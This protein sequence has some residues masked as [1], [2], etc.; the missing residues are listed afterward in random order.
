MDATNAKEIVVSAHEAS[1][2][3][4]SVRL[5]L[6][7]EYVT[8]DDATIGPHV[9]H[10]ENLPRP[11]VFYRGGGSCC[12]SNR[13]MCETC[14]AEVKRAESYIVMAMCGSLG[15]SA[16][17]CNAFGYGHDADMAYVIDFCRTAFGDRNDAEI[18]ARMKAM[19]Q[20]AAELMHPEGK[21]ASAVAR[22]L[23]ARR[24]LTEAEVTK[25][26]EESSA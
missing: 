22:E 20:R 18:N 4:A 19:L 23:R 14:R 15:V 8:L 5:G 13:S 7:F 16:T 2:A 24:R 25:I 10:V 17:G 9:E 26:I 11:I 12:D 3:V 1:H 6:P 21:T